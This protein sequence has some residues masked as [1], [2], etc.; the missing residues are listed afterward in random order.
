M[1]TILA[2]LLI[3]LIAVAAFGF[4]TISYEIEKRTIDKQQC[5][6]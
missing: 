2:L 3:V 4:M 1:T 5:G 6:E